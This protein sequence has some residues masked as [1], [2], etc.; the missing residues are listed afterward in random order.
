MINTQASLGAVTEEGGK[1]YIGS[2]LTVYEGE[3][4]G[5]YDIE[6]TQIFNH[7]AFF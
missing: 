4:S 6:G 2:R 3:H 5:E 7:V 1:F